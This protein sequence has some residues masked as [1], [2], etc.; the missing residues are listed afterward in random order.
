M[1][2][3]PERSEGTGPGQGYISIVAYTL[4]YILERSKTSLCMELIHWRICLGV[5]R[6]RHSTRLPCVKLLVSLEDAFIALDKKKIPE[7]SNYISKAR[8][9]LI[10][11]NF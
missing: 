2:N 4:S 5:Q 8:Q 10:T 6:R 7:S 1:E 11:M 9:K 3:I